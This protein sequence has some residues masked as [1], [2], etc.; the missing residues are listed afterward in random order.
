MRQEVIIIDIQ[1]AQEI[2]NATNK[3]NVHYRGI[4]VYLQEVHTNTKTATILPLDEL[5]NEQVV[6]LDGLFE[7]GP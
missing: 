6:D 3:I 2:M 7:T 5:N 1:R 4:P